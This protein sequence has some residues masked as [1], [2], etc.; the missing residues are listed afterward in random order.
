LTVPIYLGQ[1][2]K[3]LFNGRCCQMNI[4]TR[5]EE[6]KLI[7]SQLPQLFPNIEN[8]AAK[9]VECIRAGG[10]ILVCGNGGSAAD[11]VHFTAELVS[12][13]LQE[14]RAISAIPL[15]GSSPA[16]TAIANDYCFEDVFARQVEA[17]GRRGDVL[18]GISTSG[19]SINVLKAFRRGKALGLSNI[20]LVGSHTAGCLA[21]ADEIISVPSDITPRVQECHIFIIHLICEII[22]EK[23]ISDTLFLNKEGVDYLE[24]D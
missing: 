23:M 15:T 8:A 5:W 22:E 18:V 21:L 7:H 4:N 10:K 16:L 3:E 2:Q 9:M 17:Y 14:R 20:A 24:E 19:R 11:A 13:F 12:R 6:L 1:V